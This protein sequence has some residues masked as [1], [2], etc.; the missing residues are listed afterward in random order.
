MHA[1]DKPLDRMDRL[2]DMAHFPAAVNAGATLNILLTLAVTW[3]A[4]PHVLRLFRDD[5]QLQAMAAPL[6][7]TALILVLNLLPVL[8]LRLTIRPGT[9][10][11]PLRS[12]DFFRDQHKFSDWVYL[13]ASANMAVWVL[14][15]WTL[16]LWHHT[17]A[18][19]ALWM[20]VAALLTFSPVPLRRLRPLAP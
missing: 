7:W 3:W 4:Q 16:F 14:T 6:L 13:A 11:P 15:G 8:L 1:A 19:L 5:L 9:T 12:M 20:V 17:A 18:T 10:F 2:A